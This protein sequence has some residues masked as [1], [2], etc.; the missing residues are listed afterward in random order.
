MKNIKRLENELDELG[1]IILPR[2]DKELDD[3]YKE[4]DGELLTL[5]GLEK[6]TLEMDL[7]LPELQDPFEGITTE[8][9]LF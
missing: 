6:I 9:D 5:E 8:T 7:D 1:K 4:L 2:L 3:L